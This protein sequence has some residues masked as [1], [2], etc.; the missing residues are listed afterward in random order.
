MCYSGGEVT[1]REREKLT[2][3]AVLEVMLEWET[4]AVEE[5]LRY[6]PPPSCVWVCVMRERPQIEERA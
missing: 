2:S 5:E 6:I 4:V 1:E 3:N